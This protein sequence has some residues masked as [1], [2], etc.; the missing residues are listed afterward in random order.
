MTVLY[1]MQATGQ[2]QQEPVY[3]VRMQKGKTIVASAN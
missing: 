2:Q 1:L 3:H